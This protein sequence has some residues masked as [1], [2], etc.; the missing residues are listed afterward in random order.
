MMAMMNLGGFFSTAYLALLENIGFASAKSFTV[1]SAVCL[2]VIAVIFS[3]Y[4][5]LS[6]ENKIEG[7][8]S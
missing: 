7:A 6:K 3:A 4:K 8:V 1:V 5:L 2:I